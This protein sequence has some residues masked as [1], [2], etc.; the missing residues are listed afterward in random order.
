MGTSTA[1]TPSSEWPR[2]ATSLRATTYLSPEDMAGS[3]VLFSRESSAWRWHR[4]GKAQLNL[5]CA[6]QK[7]QGPT[8]A[9][10]V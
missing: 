2:E 5:P 3:T 8:L 1:Q 6:L 7:R 10:E 9:Q 4:W